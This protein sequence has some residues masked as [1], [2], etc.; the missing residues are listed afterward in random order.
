VSLRRHQHAARVALE[1]ALAEFLF[2]FLQA[3]GDRALRD[4]Q[5]ARRRGHR[6][7]LATATK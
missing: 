3:L 2:Q 7:A 6:A 4:I 5:H 1:Q